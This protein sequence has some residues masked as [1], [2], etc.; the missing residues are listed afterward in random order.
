MNNI[1]EKILLIFWNEVSWVI[2]L[3]LIVIELNDK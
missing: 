2:I 1:S 3:L